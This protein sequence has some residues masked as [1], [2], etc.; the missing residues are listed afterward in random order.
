MGMLSCN[1][2]CS[3]VGLTYWFVVVVG[4]GCR[5]LGGLSMA[6]V[7]VDDRCCVEFMDCIC[8]SKGKLY[9]YA[10]ITDAASRRRES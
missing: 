8:F 5:L 4:L 2:E 6:L 7:I 9:V 10:N 3:G 1:V